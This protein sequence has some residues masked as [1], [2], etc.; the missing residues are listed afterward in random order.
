[1]RQEQ[2]TPSFDLDSI[3]FSLLNE[4]Q[5]RN[6][7]IFVKITPKMIVRKLA[8]ELLDLHR[9]GFS[10]KKI[11]TGLRNSGLPTRIN[12]FRMYMKELHQESL[13]R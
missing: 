5:L 6:Q 12:T 4:L 10:Y 13:H 8:D 7:T 9:N 1:M 11:L 2:K 3:K